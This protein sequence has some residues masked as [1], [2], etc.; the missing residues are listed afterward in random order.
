ML[1]SF[2]PS[3]RW[4]I[5]GATGSGKSRAAGWVVYHAPRNF[6]WFVI[7]SKED[8]L[9]DLK[10]YTVANA[11]RRLGSIWR[12]MPRI[13]RIMPDVD[14]GADEFDDFFRKVLKKE[15]V[16]VVVDEAYMVP[17]TPWYKRVLT[18]GRTKNVPIIICSQRPVDIPRVCISEAS[19]YM[20]F[21]LTDRR[22]R[23]K[24]AGFAPIDPKIIVEKHH[25][26]YYDAQLGEGGR[27]APLPN[28]DW[29]VAATK[30]V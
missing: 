24:V 8:I 21:T 19:R 2:D 4:A 11:T 3:E 27:Y 29:L 9:P 26:A 25:F 7:D 14:E 1:R 20:V 10:G 6:P 28:K 17:E 13:T 15:D 18:T 30:K 23:D 22:D 12:K 16:G 5:F